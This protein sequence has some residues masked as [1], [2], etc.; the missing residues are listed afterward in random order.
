MYE[1]LLIPIYNKYLRSQF[2][3]CKNRSLLLLV[4]SQSSIRC[5]YSQS[6]NLFFLLKFWHLYFSNHKMPWSKNDYMK[7]EVIFYSKENECSTE[8]FP[9]TLR[10]NIRSDANYSFSR[11][12]RI[13]YYQY[14]QVETSNFIW[15]DF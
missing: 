4:K 15:C 7:L 12:K 8:Y 9:I 14:Y 6:F 11:W 3:M 10:P 2:I 5:A 13:L 1:F